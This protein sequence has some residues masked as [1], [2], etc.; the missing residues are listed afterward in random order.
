MKSAGLGPIGVPFWSM[1]CWKPVVTP[2]AHWTAPSA[3]AI[4]PPSGQARSFCHGPAMVNANG[5]LKVF[6]AY[7]PACRPH[8][9]NSLAHSGTAP[10]AVDADGATDGDGSTLG[11]DATESGRAS[12]GATDGAAAADWAGEPLLAPPHPASSRA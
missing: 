10:A 11:L 2:D 6:A 7:V 3:M 1:P 5:G 9:V 4:S 12:D 8:V